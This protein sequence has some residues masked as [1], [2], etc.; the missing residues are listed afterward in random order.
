ML[1]FNISYSIIVT[2]NIIIILLMLI[3]VIKIT[4]IIIK[5]MYKILR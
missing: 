3:L 1:F 4:V 5:S 2:K